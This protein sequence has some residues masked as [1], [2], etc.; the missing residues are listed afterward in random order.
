MPRW[1]DSMDRARWIWAAAL[2]VA[3]V[4]TVG[5]LSLT[6]IGPTG[7]R[8][9][10]RYPCE[11][12]WYQRIL[13]YPLVLVIGIGLWRRIADLAWLV[14]P[15]SLLGLAVASYHLA[16][17]RWPFLEPAQCF[18]G[19]CTYPDPLF[20]GLVTVPQLSWIAFAMIS[21][22]AGAAVWTRGIAPLKAAARS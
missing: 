11:L 13:M 19:S 10:G 2:L 5:S 12:C 22:L 9:L 4:A 6:G 7:W 16:I 20:D 18:V 3:I 14:L 15:L 1:G 17:Q 21:A 8:G